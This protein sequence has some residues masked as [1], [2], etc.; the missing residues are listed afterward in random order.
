MRSYIVYIAGF[1]IVFIPFMGFVIFG[2]PG[3]PNA[4]LIENGPAGC[5]CEF[6]NEPDVRNNRGGVRQPANTWS[7]MYALI[8]AFVVAFGLS[9]DRKLAPSVP[10]AQNLIRSQS[11]IADWYVF[12][13]MFLGLG[14]MWFHASITQWGGRFDGAS[15]YFF[16]GYM[17]WYSV[18]RLCPSALLF[19]I[20]YL[21]TVLTFTAMHNWA[22][23][24]LL[25]AI[26]V[27]AYL[28]LEVVIVFIKK[29]AYFNGWGWAL[30]W[31]V[32]ALASFGVAFVFWIGGQDGNFLC[33]SSANQQSAFQAHGLWHV[34]AGVMAIF[35]YYYW[36]RERAPNS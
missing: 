25:I 8:T 32:C 34:F 7:N 36:R 11:F 21:L 31:W 30:L 15:M 12:A 6:V 3:E 19:W 35:L 28:I 23:S 24:E 10:R 20:G 1:L 4:C 14:S 18:H 29:A 27:T 26:L 33:D 13:V 22:P 9:R 16:A 2:W 5:F 17:V